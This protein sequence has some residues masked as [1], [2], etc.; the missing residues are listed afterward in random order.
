MRIML[1]NFAAMAGVSGGM[2]KVTCDFANA[3]CERGHEVSLLYCDDKTGKPFYPLHEKVQVYNVQHTHGTDIVFP[4]CLKIKRELW[5]LLDKRRGRG[6]NDEFMRK[7]LVGTVQTLYEEISPDV[8]VTSQPA[9]N[10]IFLCEM[11]V[12]TPVISMSHGDPEDYFHIYPRE[13]IPSIPKSAACQVLLPSFV[14]PI[15]RRFPQVRTVVIGNVVPQYEEQADLSAVKESYK[16]VF[17]G[18]LVK[19]HKRPHLFIKAFIKLAEKFPDWQAELWGADSRK[20]YTRKL[21][22]QI[23]RAGLSHRIKLMGTTQ[24]IAAVLKN[25]D[26]FVFPSAYEGWG[27]ALTEAMSMGVPAIGYKNC[28]AVNELIKHGE[29]GLLAEDGADGL[30]AAMQLLM[31]DKEARIRMGEKARQSVHAYSEAAIWTQWEELMQDICGKG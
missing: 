4:A 30:A 9:A 29:N 1:A 20:S 18:R 31:S 6:V 13:E 8:I 2:Q 26:L 22:H 25:A 19:N 23:D 5:R 27:L 17:V 12:K 14:E 11:D 3:M 28:V 15:K 21:Q 24:N 16:I 10:A 7:Y